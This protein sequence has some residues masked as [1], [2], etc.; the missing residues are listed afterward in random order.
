MSVLLHVVGT[1]GIANCL[2]SSYLAFDM[3]QAS[4]LA[5]LHFIR[6]SGGEGTLR[7]ITF[8][9]H[10]V[11]VIRLGQLNKYGFSFDAI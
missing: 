11:A 4:I 7:K 2:Y 5:V 9:R 1:S 6:L 8:K 3:E 10:T